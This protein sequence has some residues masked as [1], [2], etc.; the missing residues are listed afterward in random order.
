M[1]F[2]AHAVWE[3][4]NFNWF[5]VVHNF[6]SFYQSTKFVNF[7]ENNMFTSE[8]TYSTLKESD[9]VLNYP[10]CGLK[11]TRYEASIVSYRN[12]ENFRHRNIFVKTDEFF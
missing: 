1:Q 10:L 8:H 3:Y 11:Y 12:S 4:N 9:V 7:F 5:N 6:S 2:Q